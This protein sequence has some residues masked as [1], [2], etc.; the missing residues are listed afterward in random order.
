M[1]YVSKKQQ[2]FFHSPGAK[3]KIPPSVVEEFDKASKGK[4][5]PKT[6]SKTKRG[7]KKARKKV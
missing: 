2:G 6:A 3:G 4:K 5:I 7:G 1:P